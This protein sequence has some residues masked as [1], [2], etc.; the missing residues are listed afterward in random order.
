ML[1]RRRG[2]GNFVDKNEYAS[3]DSGKNSRWMQ[4]KGILPSLR[5]GRRLAAEAPEEE[6]EQRAAAADR[7]RTKET[8]SNNADEGTS[9]APEE[10]ETKNDSR[11][12]EVFSGAAPQQDED[13]NPP[14]DG[15]EEGETPGGGDEGEDLTLS[16]EE[17]VL[18]PPPPIPSQQQEGTE[19]AQSSSSQEAKQQSGNNDPSPN[20]E[21]TT[22]T[23]NKDNPSDE[24]EPAANDQSE[25]SANANGLH[26]DESSSATSAKAA[27]VSGDN[28]GGGDGNPDAND[29]EPGEDQT[30]TESGGAS[31]EDGGAE[32]KGDGDGEGQTPANEEGGNKTRPP[33]PPN[34]D[35]KEH[36]DVVEEKSKVP[37]GAKDEDSISVE[38]MQEE[39]EFRRIGGLGIFLAVLAMI[40]TAWQMSENPDGIYAAACRL[41]ITVIGLIVNLALSPCR[42]CLGGARYSHNGGI[43]HMHQNRHTYGQIPV[44]TMDYGYRDPALELS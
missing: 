28:E 44:A 17:Q 32:A 14:E 42:S 43:G 16:Q 24:M 2:G 9:P 36:D 22:G 33:I 37:D 6:Q 18:L 12:G 15:E 40:F 8:E 41:I 4:R 23:G 29:S 10:T 11:S 35:V 21:A 25:G 26:Q 20:E 39:R 34:K 38:L 19:D 30:K 31:G 7:A 5:R 13:E 1:R 27:T 3:T